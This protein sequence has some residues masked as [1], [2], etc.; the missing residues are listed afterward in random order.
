MVFYDLH[1]HSCLSPCADAQ[2]TPNNIVNMARVCELD[3]ISVTD[4]N[5]VRQQEALRQCARRAG[6]AYV[7]GVEMESR[8]EVHLL[9]YFPGSQ[10]DAVQNW[11]NAHYSGQPNAIAYFGHQTVM[12]T[13]DEPE[14]EE[15][16]RLL[17]ALDASLQECVDAIHLFKGKAVLAHAWGKSNGIIPQLGFIPPD[18]KPDGIEVRT[19]ADRE[20]VLANSPW[21]HPRLWLCSSDAHQLIDIHEK[22]YSISE[23]EAAWLK[24]EGR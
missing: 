10:I 4:H 2:M 7:C 18:L 22:Q 15:P 20:K 24:G 12:N 13:E 23:E 14:A 5:T 9:G 19:W 8:E 3:L 21:I 6:I 1:L 16:Q 11:L 17:D